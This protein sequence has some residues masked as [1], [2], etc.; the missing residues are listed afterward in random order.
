MLLSP[1]FGRLGDTWSRWGLVGIGVIVWSLASGASGLATGF[2]VLLVTRC[3]VGVGEAAYGPV[4]P[5]MLSDLYPER[6][7][8]K[9]MAWFYMAIPVGSALGF[10][11]GG[12]S[13][14]TR[15]WAGAGPSRWSSCPAWCWGP[16]LLH[17]RART[18]S[19][20]GGSLRAVGSGAQGVEGHP[21]VRPV[22][23]RD[24]VHDVRPRRGR[25]VGPVLLLRARGP[26]PDHPRGPGR[27]RE[28][29]DDGRYAGDPAGGAQ[30]G[31]GPG[32][33][34]GVARHQAGQGPA[35]GERAH[36][37]GR[38]RFTTRGSST[39]WRPRGTRP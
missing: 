8:G 12:A 14:P 22:L 18:E 9:V 39:G 2:W 15:P 34:P 29:E 1:V 7:R 25:G 20:R 23:R 37:A 26:L 19:R 36:A 16:V 17:A 11:I 13:W 24:D 33:R 27:P 32:R 28:A 6:H 3:F 4:A 35:G 38:R 21:L 31:T 30:Q 5:A 10:V